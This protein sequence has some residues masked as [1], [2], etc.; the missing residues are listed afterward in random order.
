MKNLPNLITIARIIGTLVLLV[1]KPFSILFL[2]LYFLCGITD[3]VDG[4]IARKFNL[5]SKKGQILDSIADCFMISVLLLIVV[6][7]FNLPVWSLCWIVLI[8]TIRLLSL[9]IGFIRYKRLAFLH[10]Y[11][12]KVTGFVLFCYPFLYIVLD[13]SLTTILVCA[14]ASISAL[15]ELIINIVSKVLSR[16]IKSIL[17]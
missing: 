7:N 9:V 12:N 2:I 11:T 17:H 6:L 3:I 16:D 1:I 14:I 15:E 13:F 5:V 10:T 4:V 8:A